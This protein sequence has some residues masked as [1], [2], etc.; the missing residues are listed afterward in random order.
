[1]SACLPVCCLELR[2]TLTSHLDPPQ[3]HEPRLLG[4]FLLLLPKPTFIRCSVNLCGRFPTPSSQNTGRPHDTTMARHAGRQ[5][6]PRDYDEPYSPLPRPRRGSV[7]PAEPDARGWWVGGEWIEA[8]T[9]QSSTCN[10]R[11]CSSPIVIEDDDASDCY[12]V[13]PP[14]SRAS[15]ACRAAGTFDFNDG[16]LGVPW[17]T[18][19]HHRRKYEV[20]RDPREREN[21]ANDNWSATLLRRQRR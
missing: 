15:P 19:I 11:D 16:S 10:Q 1:V 9:E 17:A 2:F 4:F 5:R 13:P 20:S 14:V 8:A 12:E 6:R 21:F 18:E 7:L 3:T